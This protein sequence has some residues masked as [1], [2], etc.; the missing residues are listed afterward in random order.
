MHRGMGSG[1]GRGRDRGRRRPGHRGRDTRSDA[2]IKGS[3]GQG[4]SRHKGR[5]RG[6]H[7]GRGR[8]RR[9][10]RGRSCVAARDATPN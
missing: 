5:R 7:K 4:K 1:A 3:E 2:K 8:S 9:G 10:D 6:R